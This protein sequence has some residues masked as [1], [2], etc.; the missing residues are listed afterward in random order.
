MQRQ[1]TVVLALSAIAVAGFVLFGTQFGVGGAATGGDRG[2]CDGQ[3]T[4]Q[5]EATPAVEE[6]EADFESSESGLATAPTELTVYVEDHGVPECEVSVVW[7]DKGSGEMTCP[8]T[9]TKLTSGNN[10]F[11][12][13]SDPLGGYDN[14]NSGIY[15]SASAACNNPAAGRIRKVRARSAGVSKNVWR[16]RP[17]SASAGIDIYLNAIGSDCHEDISLQKLADVGHP[18]RVRLNTRTTISSGATCHRVV[19]KAA[20]EPAIADALE[21]QAIASYVSGRKALT[22][23]IVLGKEEEKLWLDGDL[24]YDG[25][26][27]GPKRFIVHN[28]DAV[29]EWHAVKEGDRV[30]IEHRDTGK[31]V[32]LSDNTLGLRSAYASGDRNDGLFTVREVN[33]PDNPLHRTYFVA[34]DGGYLCSGLHADVGTECSLNTFAVSYPINFKGV[35]HGVYIGRDGDNARLRQNYYTWYLRLHDGGSMSNRARIWLLSDDGD[36]YLAR[37]H[38]ADKLTLSPRD[39]NAGDFTFLLMRYDGGQ[40]GVRQERYA[41]VARAQERGWTT[42]PARS[43]LAVGSHYQYNWNLIRP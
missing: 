20:H 37:E 15:I 36:R 4:G 13:G 14:N 24:N 43:V 11:S 33:E 2:G 30:F 39:G 32:T 8:A 26:L 12:C 40:V 10:S 16:F 34:S 35:A 23:E 6:D 18:V 5:T 38:D 25:A 31:F 3:D 27:N 28:L 42:D 29:D 21:N 9:G 41:Q 17:N 7:F 1:K 19:R 22:S